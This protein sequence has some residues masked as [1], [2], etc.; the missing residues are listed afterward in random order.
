ML[1]LGL[2]DL[3]VELFQVVTQNETLV[4][5]QTLFFC[6]MDGPVVESQDPPPDG[7][8]VHSK[9]SPGLEFRIEAIFGGSLE[10]LHGQF[11]FVL[12]FE[13]G[14]RYFP[15]PEVLIDHCPPRTQ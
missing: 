7:G 5:G 2:D 4:Q 1:L 3:L 8:I 12:P 6:P 14:I 11:L 9:G 13:P 15:I 10:I